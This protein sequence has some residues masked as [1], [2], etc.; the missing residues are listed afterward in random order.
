VTAGKNE[1]N[2]KLLPTHTICMRALCFSENK[3]L[4]NIPEELE[5]DLG[6]RS[7]QPPGWPP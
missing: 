1:N 4:E 2:S 7:G 6:D 3:N 5:G